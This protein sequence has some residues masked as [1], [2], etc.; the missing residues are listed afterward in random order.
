MIVKN[1][2]IEEQMIVFDSNGEGTK[3]SENNEKLDWFL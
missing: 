1:I 2:C 3:V